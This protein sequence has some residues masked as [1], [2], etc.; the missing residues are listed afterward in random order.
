MTE[1]DND[2]ENP[3]GGADSDD[4]GEPNGENLESPSADAPETPPVAPPAAARPQAPSPAVAPPVNTPDPFEGAESDDDD[5]DW[6]QPNEGHK[7]AESEPMRTPPTVAQTRTLKLTECL[8]RIRRPKPGSKVKSTKRYSTSYAGKIYRFR[9]DFGWYRV[10]IPVGQKLRD[11]H[12]HFGDDESPRVFEVANLNRAG[13][14]EEKEQLI[15]KKSA[16]FSATSPRSAVK[17][18]G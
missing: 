6:G 17:R 1:P 7:P 13:Q 4:L 9:V 10:P 8:V 11:V 3:E 2:L 15:P 14:I 5:E 16:E 12:V 18:G